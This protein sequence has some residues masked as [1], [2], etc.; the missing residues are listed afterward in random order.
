[1]F[2]FLELGTVVTWVGQ[3][4]LHTLDGQRHMLK[5]ICS[6]HNNTDRSV[7][8]CVC[9]CVCV[10]QRWKAVTSNPQ[11][12]NTALRTHLRGREWLQLA[13]RTWPAPL[14]RGERWTKW[15]VKKQR[16]TKAVVGL[17]HGNRVYLSVIVFCIKLNK[18]QSLLGGAGLFW[19]ILHTE[20]ISCKANSQ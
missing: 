5:N 19:D 3:K 2:K 15:D 18:L 17:L 7:C 12:R 20:D 1:M 16:Y 6:R 9:V 14:K 10:S 13:A 11:T 8:V 4:K